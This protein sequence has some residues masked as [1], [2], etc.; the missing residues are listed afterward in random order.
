MRRERG[1]TIICLC[2]S[3]GRQRYTDWP[4]LSRLTGIPTLMVFTWTTTTFEKLESPKGL[5]GVFSLKSWSQLT[6][7]RYIWTV[8]NR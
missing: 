2:A 1:Q 6:A 8:N 5:T 3:R 7:C 4:S